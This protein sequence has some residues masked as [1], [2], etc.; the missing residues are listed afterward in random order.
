MSR[1][2]N[3]TNLRHIRQKTG[4]KSD[5][6]FYW[7]GGI[8]IQTH[9]SLFIIINRL[10]RHFPRK[11]LQGLSEKSDNVVPNTLALL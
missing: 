4:I 1:G 10:F 3:G 8:A 6:T 11:M 5:G 7:G 2:A 9:F